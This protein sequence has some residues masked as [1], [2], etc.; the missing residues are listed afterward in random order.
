MVMAW[1]GNI[2]PGDLVGNLPAAETEI[3]ARPDVSPPVTFTNLG[4]FT[5][6]NVGT[7]SLQ[8]LYSSTYRNLRRH[9]QHHM[10]MISR[11]RALQNIDL[12]AS[13]RFPNDVSH[14]LRYSLSQN[15]MPILGDPNH[16]DINLK[17]CLRTMT[18][19]F[20]CSEAE[21]RC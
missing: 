20:H 9:R 10:H 6:Q 19:R 8:L 1:V 2:R 13:A 18:M 17:N 21:K 5:Q 16:V 4:T 12:L 15:L 3:A 11:N 7:L 14:P